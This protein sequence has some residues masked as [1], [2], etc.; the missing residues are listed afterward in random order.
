MSDQSSK[1]YNS[2]NFQPLQMEETT[3]TTTTTSTSQEKLKRFIPIILIIAGLI[4]LII[5]G[6]LLFRRSPTTTGNSSGTDP[7]KAVVLQWWGTFM[8]L[9]V[10][11]PLIDQYKTVKPNVTIEY[12]N[13]WPDLTYSQAE[14]KYKTE[15]N[16]V[17]KLNDS[18]QLPD[19]FMLNNHWVG[20]YEKYISP[21]PSSILSYADFRTTY[22]DTVSA[23]FG[24]GDKVSGLPLWIDTLAIV[25]NKDLLASE[26]VSTPP[27]DWSQFRSLALKLTKKSG[28]NV[29]QAGFAGGISS[30]VSY[31]FELANILMMQNGVNIVDA[32][33]K[34]TFSADADSLTSINF[35][36]DFDKGNNPTWSSDL[37]TDA[38]AFLEGDLAMMAAPSYR[39][40]DVLRYNDGYQ[41][42]LNIGI[43]ALPQLAGQE[44]SIINWGDYWGNTVTL[45]RPNKEYAWEFLKWLSEP[46]Q[47][48]SLSANV[49][50]K[51]GFFGNLYPR[52]DLETENQSDEYLKIYNESLPYIKTWYMVNSTKIE[53]AYL[54]NFGTNAPS[55]SSVASFERDI[56]DIIATKGKLE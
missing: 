16:R 11:Q 45:N 24:A 19:I 23:D 5:L 29:T 35:L 21:A 7:N 9:E 22:Y 54:E 43:S 27:T 36:R 6:F 42:N 48:K 8:D 26:S 30:N 25:Y 38:A 2:Y 31:S 56:S 4:L 47:L 15:V 49:K 17:L 40:R 39:L 32:T 12:A 28:V 20:D 3:T 51:Y 52:K 46:A 34:P 1:T 13:K 37:K 33:G 14:S 10:I 44:Q 53:A 55:Q 18:V 41:L 50:N